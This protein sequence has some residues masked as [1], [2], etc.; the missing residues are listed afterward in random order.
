MLQG[1]CLLPHGPESAASWRWLIGWHKTKAL[2]WSPKFIMNPKVRGHSQQGRHP[3]YL[4][5]L[6][7]EH[8]RLPA[9]LSSPRAHLDLLASAHSFI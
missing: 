1:P 5:W 3:V 8:L 7:P 2:H 4:L 6:G 9:A